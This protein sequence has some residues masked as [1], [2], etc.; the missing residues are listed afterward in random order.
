MKN[1]R[2]LSSMGHSAK[3]PKTVE[4]LRAQRNGIVPGRL[5]RMMCNWRRQTL[6]RSSIRLLRVWAS[7][8]G[9]YTWRNTSFILGEQSPRAFCRRPHRVALDLLQIRLDAHAGRF[10]DLYR[11]GSK[12]H[13]SHKQVVGVINA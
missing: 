7:E 4:K 1:G 5:A 11:A 12:L 3:W 10:G 9:R 6:A 13:W 2:F 8:T